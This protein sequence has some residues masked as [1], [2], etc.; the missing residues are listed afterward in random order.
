MNESARATVSRERK[1]LTNDAT[2]LLASDA[3]DTEDCGTVLT[4]TLS[5]AT[6]ALF[7]VGLS[8]DALSAKKKNR[9]LEFGSPKTNES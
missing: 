7:Q 6:S 8:V 5:S 2:S 9:Q 3:L 1:K 4:L